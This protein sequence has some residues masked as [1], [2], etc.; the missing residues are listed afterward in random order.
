MA[1]LLSPQDFAGSIGAPPGVGAVRMG[2][3]TFAGADF[4]AMRAPQGI[5]RLVMPHLG[6]TQFAGWLGTAA[7]AVSAYGTAAPTVTGGAARGPS[8]TSMATRAKRTGFVSAV[9]AG[10]LSSCYGATGLVTLG[11]GAGLGGFL[12]MFRF[13]PGDAAT[14]SGARMFVGLSSATGAPSNVEPSGLTNQIGVAQL[15]GSTNLQI[16]FGGGTAQTAIDLGSSFP[17][18]GLGTDLYELIL[19]SDPNDNTKVGYRV[20]R[21][22]TANVAE[23]SL[24]NTTPGTTLPATGTMLTMRMWRTNNATALAVGFDVVSAVTI[25]DF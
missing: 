7:N 24:T 1:V 23:G 20:E 19:F 22:N 10:T 18:S 17:A 16:V 21:L 6:R 3:R 12:A 9:T 11:N 8:A 13:V 14:V 4:L 2:V 5:E 25:W 15:S